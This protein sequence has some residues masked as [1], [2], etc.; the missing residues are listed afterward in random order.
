MCLSSGRFRAIFVT[1]LF[2]AFCQPVVAK[3]FVRPHQDEL[4]INSNGKL[5]HVN[6]FIR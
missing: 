2:K 4:K 5:V 6:G 3:C 1:D